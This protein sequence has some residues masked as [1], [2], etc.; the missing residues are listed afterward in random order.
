MM[1]PWSWPLT[2]W[3]W[4]HNNVITSLFYPLRCVCIILSEL[5]D[6][7]LSNGLKCVDDAA[8]DSDPWSPQYSQFSHLCQIRKIPSKLS[9]NIVFTRIGW[10]NNQKH[11]HGDVKKKKEWSNILIFVSVSFWSFFPLVQRSPLHLEPSWCAFPSTYTDFQNRTHPS[12]AGR[13]QTRSPNRNW[14]LCESL[15]C[16]RGV[17]LSLSLVDQV[18]F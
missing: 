2:Y 17:S 12:S 16:S 8:V 14:S 7:V 1:S 4:H 10:T 9:W 13:T 6:E 15:T 18:T 5:S 3:I 11:L